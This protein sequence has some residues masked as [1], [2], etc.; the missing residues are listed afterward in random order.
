MT[1][2]SETMTLTGA[3]A[4]RDGAALSTR[5]SAALGQH[6]SLTIDA[7]G[8]TAADMA[9]IQLLIATRKSASA[10][11]KPF[12]L[13]IGRTGAMRDLFIKAGFAAADGNPLP[14]HQGLW[15]FTQS[16]SQAA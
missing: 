6:K 12:E 11:G 9:I 14:P 7:T 2:S 5:L 8:V 4:L 3:L 13:K 1:N 15:T 10:A 16:R